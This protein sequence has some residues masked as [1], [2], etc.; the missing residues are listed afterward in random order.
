MR[1]LNFVMLKIA[2]KNFE[3]NFQSMINNFLQDFERSKFWYFFS[4]EVKIKNLDF[5]D[6][7][8]YCHLTKFYKKLWHFHIFHSFEVKKFSYFLISK[9]KIGNFT[10][11]YS[12]DA[13]KCHFSVNY[14]FLQKFWYFTSSKEKI[15]NFIFVMF[16]N[17]IFKR[18]IKNYPQKPFSNLWKKKFF[19]FL[20]SLNQ[21]QKLKF[22][23]IQKFVSKIFHTCSFFSFQQKHLKG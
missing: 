17:A 10:R 9:V 20:H 19:I 23:I 13:P 1:N 12:C 22:C 3:Q 16:K 18:I 4:F 14:N 2:A 6:A 5:C 7:Q 15:R 21:N 11:F 8:K